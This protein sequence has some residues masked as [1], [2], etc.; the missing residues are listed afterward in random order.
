MNT[1]YSR[2]QNQFLIAMKTNHA[3]VGIPTTPDHRVRS[4][5]CPNGS[6]A[7]LTEGSTFGKCA[8]CAWGFLKDDHAQPIPEVLQYTTLGYKSDCGTVSVVVAEIEGVPVLGA[9]R[10]RNFFQ[11]IDDNPAAKRFVSR[12]ADLLRDFGIKKTETD[13]LA[14]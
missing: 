9:I 10:G 6:A 13:L 11:A 3:T 7:P 5:H 1:G 14:A 8:G 12:H 4:P 2:E